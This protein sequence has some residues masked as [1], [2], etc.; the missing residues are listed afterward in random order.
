[1][2]DPDRARW[3]ATDLQRYPTARVIDDAARVI[4]ELADEV[5]RLRKDADVWRRVE[6]T[7]LGG[8]V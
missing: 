1:M 3:I 8:D 6:N 2:I 4:R 7:D 5:E